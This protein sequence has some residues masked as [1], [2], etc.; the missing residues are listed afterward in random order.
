MNLSENS[1]LDSTLER[2]QVK[3]ELPV[4]IT[5]IMIISV[6]GILMATFIRVFDELSLPYLLL[7]KRSN[8]TKNLAAGR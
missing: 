1:Y 4:T 5:V 7:M 3:V 6:T 8:S 2:I